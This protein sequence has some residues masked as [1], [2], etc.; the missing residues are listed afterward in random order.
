M[1][2]LNQN[3]PLETT[4]SQDLRRVLR[5]YLSGWRGPLFAVI[6]VVLLG[7]VLNWQW[8]VAL[9]VAPLLLSLLPCA[10]MCAL[11]LCMHKFGKGKGTCDSNQ[12]SQTVDK[13]P[14]H[15]TKKQ[16]DAD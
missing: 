4:L 5:Y 11:G 13:G 2:S 1:S 12:H 15:L 16:G 7:L 10:A 3:Q 14:P 6:A 9:G 8:L